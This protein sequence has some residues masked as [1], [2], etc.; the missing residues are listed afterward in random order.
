MEIGISRPGHSKTW[1]LDYAVGCSKVAQGVCEKTDVRRGRGRKAYY[2]RK[3][4]TLSTIRGRTEAHGTGQAAE[5]HD[6]PAFLGRR[7]AESTC[8][9]SRAIYFWISASATPSNQISHSNSSF[10]AS[11]HSLAFYLRAASR[12]QSLYV[13]V[14]RLNPSK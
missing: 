2:G 12:M 8:P 9:K 1:F 4:N 10:V 5:T 7:V 6:E 14:S 13:C 3:K 11:Q